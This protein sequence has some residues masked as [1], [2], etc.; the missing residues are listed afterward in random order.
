MKV[1]FGVIEG[2]PKIIDLSKINTF[3]PKKKESED[4]NSL[5]KGYTS[6]DDSDRTSIKKE[7]ELS[8][9]VNIMVREEVDPATGGSTLSKMAS[10]NELQINGMAA[11]ESIRNLGMIPMRVRV[12]DSIKALSQSKKGLRSEQIKEMVIGQK[13]MVPV[14][15]IISK[16]GKE[17]KI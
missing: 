5:N 3:K 6:L 15:N 2:E 8:T 13:N 12:T 14:E 4:S 17:G 16:V 10:L 11:F 1:N 9:A 7:T